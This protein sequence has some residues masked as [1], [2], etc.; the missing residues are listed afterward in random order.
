MF[1][2][3]STFEAGKMIV[4]VADILKECLKARIIEPVDACITIFVLSALTPESLQVAVANTF[5]P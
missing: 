2:E 4:F 5:R 3:S 1:Q